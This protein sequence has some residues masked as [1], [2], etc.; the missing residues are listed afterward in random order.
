VAQQS[1]LGNLWDALTGRNEEP[2][3]TSGLDFSQKEKLGMTPEQ[4]QDVLGQVRDYLP[5]DKGLLDAIAWHES[6]NLNHPRSIRAFNESPT[7][8]Y[9]G[10]LMQID[11]GTWKDIQERPALQKWH[12]RVVEAGGPDLREAD[13]SAAVNPLHSAI[14][15]RMK[16]LPIPEAIPDDKTDWP[17]Y[18]KQYY[19]TELGAG[20]EAKFAKDMEKLYPEL[21]GLLRQKY[22]Y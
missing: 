20:T 4:V 6:R 11:E 7:G 5:S 17:R 22:G 14:A 15:A 2:A 21:K 3:Q 16:F 10:G 13:W 12:R 18:W 19:N 9:T 1:W 8:Y